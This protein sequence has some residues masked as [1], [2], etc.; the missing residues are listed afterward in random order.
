MQAALDATGA[1]QGWL[2]ARSG[3]G[4][5]VTA[6]AG[7]EPG[8]LLGATVPVGSGTAGYVVSS[9]QPVAIAPRPDDER[10]EGG[11][12]ALI[13]RRPTS[14]LCVPCGD[15]EV[16][17]GALELVDKQGGG[18][19]SFDDVELAS[20]LAAV[21]GAALGA[22]GRGGVGSVPSP[23]ELGNE[24][25]QLAVADPPRYALIAPVVAALL[26]SG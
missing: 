2:L 21:A 13:G 17:H 26:A 11:I 25:S 19:F 15:D 9:G 7:G 5:A 4:L 14:V 1:S 3:D 6:A 16:V 12:A 22:G 23:G 18:T 8:R 10:F 20:L 24:L